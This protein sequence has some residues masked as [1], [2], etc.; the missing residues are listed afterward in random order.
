MVPL[1]LGEIQAASRLLARILVHGVT[2][3]NP[4]CISRAYE[5]GTMKLGKK[6]VAYLQ[7]FPF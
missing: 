6:N 4:G 7:I 3:S 2:S 5:A 1:T